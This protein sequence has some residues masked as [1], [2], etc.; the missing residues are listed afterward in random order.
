[1]GR[2]QRNP[3][4]RSHR[5]DGFRFAQPILRLFTR[6]PRRPGRAPRSRPGMRS[7]IPPPP[8]DARTTARRRCVA[9]WQSAAA[10]QQEDRRL[11]DR[12]YLATSDSWLSSFSGPES[13]HTERR[14]RA[15]ARLSRPFSFIRTLTVGFGIAPNLLTLLRCFTLE[16]GARGLGPFGP[17]RRWGRSPLPE[18]IG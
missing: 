5:H 10:A 6:S 8:R 12:G 16:E 11:L 2:A 17:Y 15:N 18:H 4:P 7:G 3:S 14:A 9:A 1:M 13:G